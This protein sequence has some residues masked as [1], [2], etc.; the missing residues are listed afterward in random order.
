MS[1]SWKFVGVETSTDNSAISEVR[2]SFYVLVEY[3]ACV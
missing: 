2:M 1:A 3:R